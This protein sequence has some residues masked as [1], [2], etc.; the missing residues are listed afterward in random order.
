MRHQDKQKVGSQNILSLTQE[1][2]AAGGQITQ[3][4][5]ILPV[6]ADPKDKKRK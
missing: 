3:C 5:T 4:P 2:L 1:Y 6:E